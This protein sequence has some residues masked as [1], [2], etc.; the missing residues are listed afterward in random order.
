MFSVKIEANVEVHVATSGMTSELNANAYG[1]CMVTGGSS[2]AIELDANKEP[3]ALAQYEAFC[4]ATIVT[5]N[6]PPFALRYAPA[7]SAV[8]HSVDC[9]LN[10]F[11]RVQP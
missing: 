10:A 11:V 1:C 7:C 9:A 6:V 2:V 5:S 3:A 8:R 4:D